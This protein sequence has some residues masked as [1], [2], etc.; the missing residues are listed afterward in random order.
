MKI[1]VPF[2]LLLSFNKETAKQK[3]N[4]KVPLGYLA[5]N[6]LDHCNLLLGPTFM[7]PLQPP[8]TTPRRFPPMLRL[9]RNN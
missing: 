3:G 4:K 9:F 2:F 6:V 8:Y 5:F 1:T 7:V